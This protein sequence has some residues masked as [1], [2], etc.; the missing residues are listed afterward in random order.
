MAVLIAVK[1]VGIEHTGWWSLLV[2]TLILTIFNFTVKPIVKFFAWPINFITLGLTYFLINIGF[3][4]LTSYLT[5]GFV[6]ASLLEA[7]F[8][9][10][11]LAIIQW[12][13]S[14]FDF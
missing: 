3:L 1:I 8:F 2:F 11:V 14:R 13:L 12:I 5:K 4:L 10:L 9:G 7:I 6:F